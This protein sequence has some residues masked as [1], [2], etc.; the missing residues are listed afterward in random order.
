MGPSF[1]PVVYCLG[2]GQHGREVGR[3]KLPVSL[4]EGLKPNDFEPQ[5]SVSKR[6]WAATRETSGQPDQP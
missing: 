3:S 2:R 4:K 6:D 5:A 1:K